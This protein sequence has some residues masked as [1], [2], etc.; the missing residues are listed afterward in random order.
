MGHTVTAKASIGVALAPVHGNSADELLKS[1][2]IALYQAKSRRSL[3]THRVF[4]HNRPEA[5]ITAENHKPLTTDVSRQGSSLDV[6]Q[7]IV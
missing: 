4:Q 1:A 5:V 6:E 3:N 7:Y 2:D